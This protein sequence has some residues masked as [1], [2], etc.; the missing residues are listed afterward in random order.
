MDINI[1]RSA[2]TVAAFLA[3][4]GVCLWAWSKGRSGAFSEAAMLPFREEWA[5]QPAAT[6]SEVRESDTSARP[7]RFT[8]ERA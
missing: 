4:V 5:D 7:Q 1:L 8:G 2:A 3:F 6:A